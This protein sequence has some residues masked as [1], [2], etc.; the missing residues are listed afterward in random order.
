MA[1]RPNDGCIV[2]MDDIFIYSSTVESHKKVIAEVLKCLEDF[3][4]KLSQKKCKLFQEEMV[5]LGH[6]LKKDG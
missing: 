6:K 2:Y 5:F 4:L 1:G 3:G